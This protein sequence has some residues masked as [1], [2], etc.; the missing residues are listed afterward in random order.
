MDCKR[1]HQAFQRSPCF[2]F[3]CFHHDTHQTF[4]P[5]ISHFLSNLSSFSIKVW[6]HIFNQA[7][8]TQM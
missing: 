1:M 8:H 6:G 4:A 5:M 7:T 2:T 3:W